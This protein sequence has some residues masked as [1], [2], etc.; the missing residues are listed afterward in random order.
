MRAAVEF[1]TPGDTLDERA[2]RD[3]VPYDAWV[4]AGH[5]HAPP[6]RAVDYGFVAHRIGELAAMFDLVGIA[7]DPYRIKYLEKDLDDA[8]VEVKLVP[9]GQG[10]GRSSQSGLWMPHSVDT[11]EAHILEGTMQIRESPVLNWNAASA[12]SVA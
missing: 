7:F 2:R 4:R 12:Y 11:L 8:S 1:W 5:L 6:G 10:V 9:H 3:R